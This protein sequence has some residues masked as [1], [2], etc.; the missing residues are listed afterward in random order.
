AALLAG[1]PVILEDLS[2]HL[3][4]CEPAGA[5]PA[6]L[7]DGFEA[8]SPPVAR[9]GRTSYAPP[10]GWLVTLAGAGGEG[11]GRGFLVGCRPPGP[12]CQGLVERAA[13]ALARAGLLTRQHES[14]ERQAHTT[15]IGAIAAGTYPDMDE[16]AAR[17]RALGVQVTGRQLLTMVAGFRQGGRG[18]PG[19]A[20]VL[21]GGRA[22]AAA[23]PAGGSSAP[24][25]DTLRSAVCVVPWAGPGAGAYPGWRRGAPP[26][27]RRRPGDRGRVASGVPRRGAPVAARGAAGRRGRGRLPV[28]RPGPPL[29]PAGGPAAARPAALARR[30]RP[31]GDVRGAGTR[32]AARP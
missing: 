6:G 9:G 5:D 15:L 28:G 17:A 26:A 31:A 10:S 23:R 18:V 27:A 14:L 7:L 13:T 21:E 29:L 12:G 19:H 8:P 4:S 16:A 3:L 22:R 32:P 1:R 24:G 30:R 20:P 25:S 11:W 2:H